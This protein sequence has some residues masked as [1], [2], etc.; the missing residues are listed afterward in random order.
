ML[1]SCVPL[2]PNFGPEKE[3]STSCTA[4]IAR[5]IQL[6]TLDHFSFAS[7][8]SRCHSRRD[9]RSAPVRVVRLDLAHRQRPHAH[10]V[11]VGGGSFDLTRAP[12][13][14]TSPC[15]RKRTSTSGAMAA[16]AQHWPRRRRQQ[17][18]RGSG[19]RARGA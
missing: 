16:G 2:A 14:C 17:S 6:F 15:A 1:A 12:S 19:A 18:A 11:G 10:L 7:P 8:P 3:R 4:T 9:G 13:E 5:P